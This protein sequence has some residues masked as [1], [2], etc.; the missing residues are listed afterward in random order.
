M[1]REWA[2]RFK[3]PLALGIFAAVATACVVIFVPNKYASEA[4][5][6]PVESK[7]LAGNLG[8][9]AATAAAFGVAIPSAE[10]ND[11][12]FVDILQSRTIKEGLLLSSF[13]FHQPAWR[14]GKEREH[15]ETLQTYLHQKN[16]DRGILEFSKFYSVSR[17]LKSKIITIKVDTW[18]PELSQAIV[19]KAIKLLETFVQEKGRT[20]GGAKALFAEARLVEARKEAATAE[21]EFRR[22]LDGNRNYSVSSDPSIRLRG[23]RLEAELKLRQQLVMTLAVNREQA[24]MDEKNDIPIL[25][26]MD[27]GNLPVEKSGP[28]RSLYVLTAF[29]AGF[30]G[31]LSWMY[32]EWILK[33]LIDADTRRPQ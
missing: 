18:S 5:I 4:R 13:S 14:F 31:S 1:I 10:G 21:E 8:G 27:P 33:C 23:A 32:R 6:L 25:N 9:L 3:R 24:L 11:A 15:V 19:Q 20:R 12:N 16:L 2:L 26:V 17:D 29:F 30:F 7:S 28:V 22:F